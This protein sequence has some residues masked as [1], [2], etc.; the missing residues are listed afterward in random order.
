MVSF[1]MKCG[2]YVLNYFSCL[3]ILML[4]LAY[5]PDCVV[6]WL[7]LLHIETQ[8]EGTSHKILNTKWAR[9]SL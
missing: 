4:R 9:E 5:F 7:F 8:V 6:S 1:K 3:I 2:I